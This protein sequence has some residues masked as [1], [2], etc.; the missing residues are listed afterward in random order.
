MVTIMCYPL[1]QQALAVVQEI[2]VQTNNAIH[3]SLLDMGDVSDTPCDVSH[4]LSPYT[5]YR[6]LLIN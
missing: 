4:T 2:P 6:S 5:I 1:L 3:L